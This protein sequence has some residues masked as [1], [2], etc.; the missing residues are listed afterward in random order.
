MTQ[1]VLIPTP[2][3]GFYLTSWYILYL[4]PLVGSCGFCLC[5]NSPK[6]RSCATC[7]S[8]PHLMIYSKINLNLFY[9]CP[10]KALN[11]S[12]NFSRRLGLGAGEYRLS[13]HPDV[14]GGRL[15]LLT[16]TLCC[17]SHAAAADA[18][19]YRLLTRHTRSPTLNNL[20][21]IMC[22]E[23][24]HSSPSMQSVFFPAPVRALEG[25]DKD[26]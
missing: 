15:R 21:L 24:E 19:C 2:D 5:V 13:E 23:E 8:K 12:L 22:S 14:S 18:F 16:A 17:E 7:Q 25:Q 6:K 1:N 9:T 26:S 4:R 10:L 20:E 3:W 11:L